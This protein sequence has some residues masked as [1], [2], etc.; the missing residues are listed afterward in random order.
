MKQ[1]ST[2]LGLLMLLSIAC[3]S[4]SQLFS[5]G[6]E[7][8]YELLLNS[9]NYTNR[10]N[11]SEFKQW[12]NSDAKGN[13]PVIYR[14]IQFY[15]IPNRQARALLAQHGIALHDYIPNNAY[16]A[17]I[18]CSANIGLLETYKTRG[19]FEI[20]PSYK[21]SFEL[22]VEDYPVHARREGGQYE[23]FVHHFPGL[24]TSNIKQLFALAGISYAT[25]D[26]TENTLIVRANPDQIQW[27][28]SQAFVY[29]IE[30]VNPPGFPEN[31]TGRTLHRSNTIN[32]D[33]P[34]GRRYD[35][36]G[37]RVMLQDD[38]IIGPHIDYQGRVPMQ[39]MSNNSGDHGDH[40]AGI[41]MSA[42]NLDSRLKGMAPGALLYVYNASGLPGYSAL[43]TTYI[44][45]GIRITSLSYSDG[46]NTG[47]TTRARDMD[48]Q[49]RIYPKLMHVFSAG[50]EGAADCGYGAGATWGNITGGH[51]AGKN[52]IAVANLS[53]IDVLSG[54][55]SRGP[56]K[57]GRIKPEI[58]AKGTSVN[59]TSNPNRYVVKSGTSMACPGVSGTLAQLYHA[60]KELNNQAEPM[61][62]LM[63]ALIMNTA[64]DI[65][66]LGPDF[67]FG[68]GRI[69]AYRALLT[70]ENKRY[71]SAEIDQEQTIIHTIVVP[72]NLKQLKLMLYWT[73]FEGIPGTTQA[74]VNNLNLKVTD[75][76]SN[77][78]LPWILDH[79]PNATTLNAIA[80]R[81][82]DSINNVEQVTID[83]PL[84]GTYCVQVTGQLVPQAYQKYFITWDFVTPEIALTYPLGG[85]S[86]VPG[87]TETIR[88]DALGGLELFSLAYSS[89]G[90][91]N[92][93][94]LSNSIP[95]DQ[96]YF[97]WT[98]PAGLLGKFLLRLKRGEQETITT[99]PF[100]VVP[101]PANL[102]VDWACADAFRIK[103]DGVYG[104]TGY[105]VRMLGEK[106]M[107]SIAYTT[108]TSY[109]FTGTGQ[110]E[111]W[112]A[113][114]AI[115]ENG[116][117]SRR[118][119]AV[120]R[121]AGV[122][123]C[124]AVDLVAENVPSAE[125]TVFQTCN[126][127]NNF[128]ISFLF[129][130]NSGNAITDLSVGYK[131]NSGLPV[132][133][134]LAVTLMPDSSYLATFAGTYDLSQPGSYAIKAWVSHP[135][136]GNRVN[137]TITKQ[138]RV[139][140]STLIKPVSYIQNFDN[141]TR[142]A[143]TSTCQSISCTLA[144]GWINLT[145]TT[146]DY[147]DWRT[148]GGSTP[149]SGTGPPFDHTTGTISGNYL[150]LE[151]TGLCYNREA[152]MISPCFDLTTRPNTTIRFWYHFY[153][154]DMGRLHVDALV[155]G[156]ILRDVINPI[157]G[158]HG[159]EW[160]EMV[161]SNI[162]A[163]VVTFRFRGITGNGT[164]SDMA[165][166]DF[167][168]LMPVGVEETAQINPSLKIYPNPGSGL[169]N[170]SLAG[171]SQPDVNVV[172]SDM[173]G[174]V[175]I[176]NHLEITGSYM[177]HVLD[178]SHLPV[179]IYVIS[180][181]NTTERTYQRLIKQ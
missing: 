146:E 181:R 129:R 83:N 15:A 46:C 148:F 71:D 161:I 114:Q 153:G 93:T 77:E 38:G 132:V 63:K 84:A 175:L 112:V 120:M 39:Y 33:Q 22:F 163:R 136:D 108:K 43:S 139:I 179:G 51:K 160:H 59:S 94:T 68:F 32:N 104:A 124:N 171:F 10:A 82:V 66:N 50:N 62:G 97:T 31:D 111:K 55:S 143:S 8:A 75:S 36:T 140:E 131:I 58:G 141:F 13:Q 130:N 99:H 48:Q 165:I 156:N 152:I 154:A 170:L 169:F 88:W 128:G 47:Y 138:V 18:A 125:W 180:A 101:L 119:L 176:N 113:V 61:G 145:N 60:Y 56:A 6:H 103:W 81:G 41:I 65:G 87:E 70:L 12:F 1:K 109:I 74:L 67:R 42:G 44:S 106:Y 98:M 155:D 149:T 172:V 76:E 27:L 164:N 26:M 49:M 11:L 117:V 133:E 123:N 116:A 53:L 23:L 96:R 40:C 80:T 122:S 167:E 79:R 57:D 166:D 85:E 5:Q 173:L 110:G 72:G 174:K 54:S 17:T 19:V 78:F 2:I 151:P 137:D 91:N 20:L 102:T 7:P 159:N 73:D 126:E 4:P 95:A 162:P 45:P 86:F 9:G 115:H 24:N 105:I 127:I 157:I 16:T 28:A 52:V 177:N 69:N 158:N 64:D 134:P 92:W 25:E 147:I 144:D 34:L 89:D 21:L 118:T 168:I 121:A 178:L 100:N 29:Y 30:P 135:Q 35:G 150:Y 37:V 3:L 142:C 14:I 90:G 107:D